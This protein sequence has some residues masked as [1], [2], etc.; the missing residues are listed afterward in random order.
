MN[1]EKLKQSA[2][3]LL[4]DVDTDEIETIDVDSTNYDDGSSALTITVTYPM[5]GGEKDGQ[6]RD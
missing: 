5:K 3:K 1:N 2:A 4:S 6:D